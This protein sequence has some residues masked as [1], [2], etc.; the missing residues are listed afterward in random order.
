MTYPI[1][2][3]A[4]FNYICTWD[5]DCLQT[6]TKG[7]DYYSATVGGIPLRICCQ[8]WEAELAQP[9]QPIG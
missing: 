9:L 5:D 6:I 8:C 3:K 1:K 2:K 4:A 7:E